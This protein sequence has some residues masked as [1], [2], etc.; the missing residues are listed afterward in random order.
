MQIKLSYL[1]IN[2]DKCSVMCNHRFPHDKPLNGCDDFDN[3]KPR[4]DVPECVDSFCVR[5]LYAQ[6]NTSGNYVPVEEMKDDPEF[7][8]A[9]DDLVEVLKEVSSGQAH[10]AHH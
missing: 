5:K 7:I 2:A 8:K 6:K 10:S 9:T 1:C 3:V 4:S